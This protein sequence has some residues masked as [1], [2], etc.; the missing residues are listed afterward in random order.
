[1]NYTVEFPGSELKLY[2]NEKVYSPEYSAVDTILVADKLVKDG[3]KPFTSVLDVGCG[4]GV[5]GLGVK[6]LNPTVLLTMS[7]VSPEAVKVARL[8]SKRLGLESVVVTADLLPA[9]GNWD[10]I[11]ANLPTYNKEDL[12]D[13]HGPESAYLGEEL[14]YYSQLFEQAPGR[15]KALVCECQKKYQKEFLSLAKKRGW[16]L[17]LQ[18]EMAFAFT[19]RTAK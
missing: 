11:T 10:I 14:T 3:Q 17:I 15:C 4:S 1:M 6:Q 7:D 19:Y 18:T 8:N 9:I 13:L 2:Y 12:V 16:V 5:V